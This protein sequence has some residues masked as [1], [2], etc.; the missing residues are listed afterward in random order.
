MEILLEVVV[1][2]F[3]YILIPLFAQS[4]ILNTERFKGIE[5]KHIVIKIFIRVILFIITLF[6]ILGIPIILITFSIITDKKVVEV[7]LIVSFIIYLTVMA[8]VNIIRYKKGDF[9]RYL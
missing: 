6:V 5:D 9:D 2:L 8:V 4:K 3:L 1:E 7:L